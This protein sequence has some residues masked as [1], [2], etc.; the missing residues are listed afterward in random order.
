MKLKLL[1]I[2]V[3]V[4]FGLIQMISADVGVG[5]SPSKMII[6]L[7]GGRTHEFE[8]MVFNVGSDPMKLSFV[9]E[10]T[11]S[12]ITEVEYDENLLVDPEP[13]PHELPIK[14]GKTVL[15]RFTPPASGE[16]YEGT[17]SALGSAGGGS[18]F[19]GSVGVASKIKIIVIPPESIFAFVTIT[20]L[21]IAGVIVFLV[22]LFFILKKMGLKIGFKKK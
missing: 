20:H 14:N 10:G 5:I 2:L 9:V 13:Q 21:I 15:V 7:E 17:I 6:Q 12:E 16:E 11:L 4:F 19:G 8:L 18:T 1:I 3:L 22:L